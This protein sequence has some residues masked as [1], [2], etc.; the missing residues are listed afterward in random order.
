MQFLDQPGIVDAVDLR[1][2]LLQ[3]LAYRICLDGIGTDGIGRSA[4]PGD[5]IFDKLVILIVVDLWKPA[6][7]GHK[8]TFRGMRTSQWAS[9]LVAL[10][11][12]CCRN[13]SAWIKVLLLERLHVR[14]TIL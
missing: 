2:G 9:K 4:I 11:R 7:I 8:D 6:T 14:D 12:P 5:I 10:V 13:N 3:R 1:N